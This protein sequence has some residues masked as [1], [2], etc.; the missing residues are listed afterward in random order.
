MPD[1]MTVTVFQVKIQVLTDRKIKAPILAG[2]KLKHQKNDVYYI[3]FEIFEEWN[4]NDSQ[5]T[6]PYGR[7]GY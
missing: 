1:P 2:K 3:F 4:V 5:K 6:G 7:K